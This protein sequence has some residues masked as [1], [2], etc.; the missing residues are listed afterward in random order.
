MEPSALETEYD[1]IRAKET[2]TEGEE[3]AYSS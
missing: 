1:C 3:N 2:E